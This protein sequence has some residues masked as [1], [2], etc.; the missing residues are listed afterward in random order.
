MSR[1]DRIFDKTGTLTEACP[2]VSQVIA[3]GDYERNEVLR[4]AACLEEHFPHSV[5]RAIVRQAAGAGLFHGERHAEVKHVVAHGIASQLEG[6][7]VGIG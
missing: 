2:Q 5:A 6:K 7:N 1:P 3:F 4:T